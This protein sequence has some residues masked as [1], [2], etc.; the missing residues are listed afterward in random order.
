MLSIFRMETNRK[1]EGNPSESATFYS[2]EFKPV[3][4]GLN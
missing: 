3:A 1:A 2:L 4:V